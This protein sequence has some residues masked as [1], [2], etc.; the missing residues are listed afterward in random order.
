VIVGDLARGKELEPGSKI[1]NTGMSG[2]ELRGVFQPAMSSTDRRSE[3]EHSESAP[4][5]PRN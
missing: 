1:Y 2:R 4:D 3:G 5:G